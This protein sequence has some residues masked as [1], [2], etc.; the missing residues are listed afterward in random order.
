MSALKSTIVETIRRILIAYRQ[1][2]QAKIV[3][4]SGIKIPI[5][6]DLP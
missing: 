2:T 3:T 5:P 4:I 1:V 6:P